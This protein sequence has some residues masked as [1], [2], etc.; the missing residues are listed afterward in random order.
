MNSES[1]N[2]TDTAR[3]ISNFEDDVARIKN[4]IDQA[5]KSLIEKKPEQTLLA[6][7][8]EWHVKGLMYHL[9]RLLKLYDIVAGEVGSRALGV[10]AD[11]IVMYSPDMQDLI[12]SSMRW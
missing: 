9:E 4:L 12:L 8:A 2:E 1:R 7:Q 5:V 6:H 10:E 11:V 3:H